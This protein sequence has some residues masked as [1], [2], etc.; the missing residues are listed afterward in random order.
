MTPTHASGTPSPGLPAAIRLLDLRDVPL[1]T[2]EVLAAVD[3]P[4]AGGVNLFV[5]VVRDHD[6]GETVD[7][8]DYTAHPTA[9]Q[10]LEE[11]AT[12][13]AEEFE[14]IALAAVHRTGHLKIGD[15]AVLVAASAA[16]RG[17]AYDA[18]RALIDRLK[19][20]VPVWKHQVFDDGRE[21]WVNSP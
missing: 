17:Q 5:G 20:T 6:H 3:D 11:V 12:G 1:D 7:H 14:V 2:A 21:E 19:A 15:I 18:S 10:R 9:L 16:H 4:A 8:L 13:V